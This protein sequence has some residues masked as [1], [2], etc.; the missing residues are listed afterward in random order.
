MSSVNDMLTNS[1][2][3]LSQNAASFKNMFEQFQPQLGKNPALLGLQNTLCGPPKIDSLMQNPA[4]FQTLVNMQKP[5]TSNSNNS[6]TSH[7]IVD[8]ESEYLGKESNDVE[9]K[10][11]EILIGN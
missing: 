9:K 1:K 11:D 10:P 2:I 8:K 5:T 7:G 3:P 4:L 6:V